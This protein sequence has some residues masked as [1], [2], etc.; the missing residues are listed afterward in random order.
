MQVWA[1]GASGSADVLGV[2]CAADAWISEVGEAGEGS[3]WKR[4]GVM[5]DR[6]WGVAVGD[7]IEVSEYFN[8]DPTVLY[9]VYRVD[10][11]TRKATKTRQRFL[12]TAIDERGVSLKPVQEA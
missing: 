11:R 9:P 6:D 7:V 3:T 1:G 12:V 5:G 8:G 10:P 4:G 2:S